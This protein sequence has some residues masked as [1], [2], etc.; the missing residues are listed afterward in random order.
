LFH[1]GLLDR[2]VEERTAVRV[3]SVWVVVGVIE[4]FEDV[5]KVVT[6]QV[7]LLLARGRGLELVA[8]MG[9]ERNILALVEGGGRP[10][11]R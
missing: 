3:A 9:G 4:M 5:T 8:A 11:S 1:Q 6:E 7:G 10:H 2:R